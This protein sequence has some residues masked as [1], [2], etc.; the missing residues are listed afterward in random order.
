ME[1]WH[2]P[3]DFHNMALPAAKA[4]VAAQLQGRFWEMHDLI[5]RN[6]KSLSPERLLALAT[7]LGLD[8]DRLKWDMADPRVEEFISQNVAAAIAMGLRGTPMFIINGKV[9]KGAQPPA[10]FK[11]LIDAELIKAEAALADGTPREDLARVLAELNGA[12][13]KY[14]RFFINKDF[15]PVSD[16]Q[17]EKKKRKIQKNNR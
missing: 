6:Q 5:F 7:Q 4:S 8:I 16:Q 13:A 14:I 1:F 12:D 10:K 3:L 15:A 2:N 11:E 9:L 17:P